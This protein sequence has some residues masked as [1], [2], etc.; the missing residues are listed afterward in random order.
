[1][2][3]RLCSNIFICLE[4]LECTGIIYAV[5]RRAS[6]KKNLTE[7]IKAFR[8]WGGRRGKKNAFREMYRVIF[9]KSCKG[10]F[11][12]L[13]W[14]QL[15]ATCGNCF[16]FKKN[17]CEEKIEMSFITLGYSF[18]FFWIWNVIHPMNRWI[19]PCFMLYCIYSTSSL[20]Q[21]VP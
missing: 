21:C 8:E 2:K 17:K 9:K 15:Q 3:E 4:H 16:L 7:R 10:K 6:V 14:H 20:P 18:S 11:F 19:V 12:M 1:M 13:R 5:S